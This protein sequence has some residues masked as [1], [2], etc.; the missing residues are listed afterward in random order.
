MN[1][2]PTEPLE[3]SE[4]R[5]GGRREAG[6]QPL[7]QGRSNPLAVADTASTL[8]LY[9][10]DEEVRRVPLRLTPGERTVVRQ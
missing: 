9:K 2:I 10:G 7:Q 8:V 6:R 1:Y 3:I 5:G 4:F